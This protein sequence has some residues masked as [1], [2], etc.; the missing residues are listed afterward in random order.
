M[1]G[2]LRPIL[3]LFG[4]TELQTL[5]AVISLVFF[6]S[7]LLGGLITGLTSAFGK[8]GPERKLTDR[9]SFRMITLGEILVIL[10]VIYYHGV[11]IVSVTPAHLIYWGSSLVIGPILG[12]LGTQVIELIF[13]KRISKNKK[14]Y[15]KYLA[16]QREKAFARRAKEFEKTTAKQE[17]DREKLEIMKR[18]AESRMDAADLAREQ[19]RKLRE[20]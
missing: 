9:M 10:F 16:L 5:L 2:F 20:A 14:V 11:V 13:N 8:P 18:A 17:A 15:K 12:M 7:C 19:R 3:E 4:F 1:I 6:L